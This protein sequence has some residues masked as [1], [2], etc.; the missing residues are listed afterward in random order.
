MTPEL[1]VISLPAIVFDVQAGREVSQNGLIRFAG[2]PFGSL[3]QSA[4]NLKH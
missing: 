1:L 4:L 3:P 2:K